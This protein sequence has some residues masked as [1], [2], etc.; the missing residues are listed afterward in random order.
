[1]CKDEDMLKETLD[2][3]KYVWY[4][5][6]MYICNSNVIPY[7]FIMDAVV[8][9]CI[10]DIVFIVFYFLA[11]VFVHLWSTINDSK[12]RLSS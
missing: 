4:Y 12:T 10:L 6:R 9:V 1:M 8:F 2:F 11:E 3:I 7:V 5:L